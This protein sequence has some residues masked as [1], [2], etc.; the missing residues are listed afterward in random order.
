MSLSQCYLRTN[1]AKE[2]Q[3]GNKD[4]K[5]VRKLKKKNTNYEQKV[6]R[7]LKVKGRQAY[8]RNYHIPL[9]P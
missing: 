1:P 5:Q 4:D 7:L 6:G 2:K 8:P 3:G 9:P